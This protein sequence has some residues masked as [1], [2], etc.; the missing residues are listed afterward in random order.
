MSLSERSDRQ[1]GNEHSVD[2]SPQP[3]YIMGR[4]WMLYGKNIIENIGFYNNLFDCFRYKS[5]LVAH[6][7]KCSD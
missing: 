4:G 6:T 3:H 5:K 7:V 2:G 1:F